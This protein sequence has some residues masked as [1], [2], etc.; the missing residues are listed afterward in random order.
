M[1]KSIICSFF[2]LLSFVSIAQTKD[3]PVLLTIDNEKITKNEFAAIFKKNNRDSTIT[4]ADLDE[5][6]KLYVNFKLKVMEAEELGMDTIP[7]FIRELAGYRQQLARPYLVDKSMTD[8]LVHE[9]YRRLQTEVRASHILVQLPADPRPEDTLAAYKQAMKI[10]AE[11]AKDP[12]SFTALARKYSDDPSVKRNGGDLGYFTALQM[13]YPFETLAYSTPVGEIGGPVR[14][15]YGYHIIKVTD[16]RPARGKV[17]VAHIMIRTEK[18]DPEGV[19]LR[20]KQRADD[21]Y[22]RLQSGDDFAE[23]AKKFSDDRS[24]S[25]HGGELPVFG[26]GKMVREFE[27]AAFA[28]ENV[29]DYT[30]PV[31]SPYGWHIIK[32]IEK[33]PVQKFDEIEKDLRIRITKDGRSNVSRESFIAKRKLEY[34]FTEDLRQ[35]KP[36]YKEVDTTYFSGKWEPSDKLKR[37]DKVIFTLADADYTQSQFLSYLLHRMR[38]RRDVKT[39]KQLITD[40]YNQWVEKNVMDYENAHLE[41]KY[42]D[43]KALI[44][45][46]RDG[47][48]LFDLTDRKVWSKAVK[49]SVGLHNYYESHL[50]DFMWKERAAYVI[51]TV[52]SKKEGRRVIQMLKNGKNQDEI[53]EA[54]NQETQLSVKVESGLKER[55]ALPILGKVDWEPGISDIINDGGKLQVVHIKEIRAAGPKAF[56]EI[57]GLITAAYQ[58]ELEDR[59]V[60][61]L[62]SEHTI[63]LNKDVLYSIH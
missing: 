6:A 7:S 47:I 25:S 14:T 21:I 1:L 13:V 58:N 46:Y 12:E 61:K 49:D 42:P 33:I 16:R 30:K 60:K 4:K 52:E 27:D 57:R 55:N 54:L 3:N 38:P 35:L 53:R 41:Q 50:D 36:F 62:R 2:V 17:R 45:E 43:F 51:Y 24:S 34:N 28:I 19:K 15:Q 18:G 39:I 8:S 9:A 11:A 26:A 32:L 63:A 23:L 37:K 59:W 44:N 5:Y 22:K 29:G 20:M 31:L 10:K 48:L 56:D 40:T